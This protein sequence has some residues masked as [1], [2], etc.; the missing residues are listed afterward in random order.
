VVADNTVHYGA[1][2]PSHIVLPV[3]ST[4]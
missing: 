1:A 4:R 3:V 2:R